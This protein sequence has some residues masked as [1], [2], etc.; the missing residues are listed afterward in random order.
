MNCV[1]RLRRRSWRRA[2]SLAASRPANARKKRRALEVV[3]RAQQMSRLVDTMLDMS[4]IYGGRF[5][6]ERQGSDIV[7]IARDGAHA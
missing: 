7:E 5:A 6:S 3:Q 4:R 1:P 2:R